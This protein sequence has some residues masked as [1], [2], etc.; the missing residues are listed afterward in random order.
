MLILKNYGQHFEEDQHLLKSKKLIYK[1]L[2]R[3]TFWSADVLWIGGDIAAFAGVLHISNM[4]IAHPGTFYCTGF[5]FIHIANG[6]TYICLI[7]IGYSAILTNIGHDNSP[8]L[9]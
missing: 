6:I 8:Q 9:F 3:L 5:V 2:K 1:V 7:F 4:F